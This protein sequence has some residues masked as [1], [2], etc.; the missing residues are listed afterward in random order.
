MATVG[1]GDVV[2]KT[3]LGKSFGM[4]VMFFGILVIALPVTVI[5]SNFS[6]VYHR[7]QAEQAEA[8]KVAEAAER[9]RQAEEAAS[10]RQSSMARERWDGDTSFKPPDLGQPSLR[11]P[12]SRDG[13]Q[14]PSPLGRGRAPML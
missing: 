5:G 2:P 13:S 7:Q 6:T 14:P 4:L 10:S 11:S 12:R 8:L 3:I 1:Y 9:R